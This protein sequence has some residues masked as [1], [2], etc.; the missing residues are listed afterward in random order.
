MLGPLAPSMSRPR[1]TD[2][3]DTTGRNHGLVDY[4]HAD[5]YVVLSW[6]P[7]IQ[8]CGREPP[9]DFNIVLRGTQRLHPYPGDLRRDANTRHFDGQESNLVF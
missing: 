7:N 5:G 4:P 3:Y 2:H 8:H 1:S 6:V 9:K